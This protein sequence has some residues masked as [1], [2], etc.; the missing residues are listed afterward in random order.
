MLSLIV[1]AYNEEKII[2]E[3]L[4]KIVNYLSGQEYNWEIIVVDDGSKD[5]TS[6]IVEGL[7]NPRIRLIKLIKN[8]GKGAAL[9]EGMVD[10]IGDYV[11][12]SDADLSVPIDSLS[13]FIEKLKEGSDVVIGSRRTKG[14]KIIKHQ[15]FLRETMGRF[16]TLLSKMV[17]RAK[18][19]DFTCGFK[20]FSAKAAHKIF[21]KSLI[22]RWSYDV[23][24]LYLAKKFGFRISEI[25]VSWINREETRVSLGSAITTSFTDLIGIRFND[26]LGKYDK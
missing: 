7:I 16:Y 14:S 4:K 9:R 23:E 2:K 11:V 5:K 8:S 6:K 19:S 17:T 25:P 3:N 24:I 12:F 15:P 26:I 10:A 13:L 1:P 20:G 21:S 18:I 22:D